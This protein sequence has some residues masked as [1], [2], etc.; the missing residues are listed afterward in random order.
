MMRLRPQIL[1]QPPGGR[2]MGPDGVMQAGKAKARVG[3]L[4]VARDEILKD[5]LG[6]IAPTLPFQNIRVSD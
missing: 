4:R 3:E 2:I 1:L 6:A 5:R